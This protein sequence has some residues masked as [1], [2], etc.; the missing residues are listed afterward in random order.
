MYRPRFVSGLFTGKKDRG[1]SHATMYVW[2]EALVKTD[3]LILKAFPNIPLLYRSGVVYQEEPR[4]QD[5]WQDCLTVMQQGWGDCED[6][7]CWRVAE[8]RVRYGVKAEA[9]F[10]WKETHRTLDF[11]TVVRLPNGKIED[12]SLNL[13]MRV[14]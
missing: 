9:E 2:L 3:E 8:L 1:L 12:P 4:G 5:D 6:L 14:G 7:A 13:G 10:F 11:H